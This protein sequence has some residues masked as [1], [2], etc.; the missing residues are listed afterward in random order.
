MENLPKEKCRDLRS[1]KTG[2]RSRH[3]AKI[4]EDKQKHE[5][6]L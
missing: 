6:Y 2:Q 1:K 5:A 4:K 3:R